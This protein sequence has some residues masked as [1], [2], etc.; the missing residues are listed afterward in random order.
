MLLQDA[1]LHFLNV[2]QYSK[3]CPIGACQQY[4][5]NK[6][7]RVTLGVGNYLDQ[8]HTDFCQLAEQK[9]DDDMKHL[10][11]CILSAL[12][13]SSL[14]KHD[15]RSET[16]WGRFR[17]CETT[18]VSWAMRLAWI[19]AWYHMVYAQRAIIHSRQRLRCRVGCSCYL[20]HFNFFWETFPQQRKWR[21]LDCDGMTGWVACESGHWV[22]WCDS[23]AFDRSINLCVS[24]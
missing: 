11:C 12:Q 15:R 6:P 17:P 24:R 20:A 7:W 14:R 4:R 2:K 10:D 13:L 5:G 16:L 21:F 22:E 18:T 19:Y 9:S 3:R 23:L 8:T 1:K